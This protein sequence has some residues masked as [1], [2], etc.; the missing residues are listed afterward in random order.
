MA[1]STQGFSG[2]RHAFLKASA[3][4]K[5]QEILKAPI[6]APTG[7]VFESLAWSDRAVSEWIGREVIEVF[8]AHPLW[9]QSH[10]ILLGSW[11]RGELSIK[12]DL[13]LLFCGEANDVFQLITDLQN[14]GYRIRYR[15]PENQK[16]WAEGVESPDCLALWHAKAETPFAA[17]QLKAQQTLIFSNPQI[18]KRI[19]KD[20]L[21]ERKS[22]AERF[23]SIQSFLEPQMKFGPG[24]LRDLFQGQVILDLFQ[25]RFEE[26]GH[27]RQILSYYL[28]FFLTLRLKLQLNG[29][30][31]VLVAPEQFELSKWFGY[32][33]NSEFM[34]QIQRGLSRVHFYSEWI[35]A[36]AAASPTRLQS[37]KKKKFK[38]AMDLFAALKKDPG[39]LTQYEVRLSMDQIAF[40]SKARGEVLQKLLDVK[41][42]DATLQAVFQSRLID[43]LVPQMKKLTGYVQH[44]QYHRFTADAHLLQA[45][46]EV[47]RLQ[48]ASKKSLGPLSLWQKK[49]KPLDWK[50]LA[51]SALYHDLA[52]GQKGDHSEIGEKWVHEDLKAFGLS[53]SF[54]DE[55]AWLVRHHLELSVAAFRKN[56]QAPQTW[57]DLAETGINDPRLLRLLMWTAIDIRATNPEAWNNWKAKLLS[58]LTGKI[59]AG[60]T[61]NFLS[62]RKKLPRG[63]AGSVI[64]ALDPQLFEIFSAKALKAD[65][66]KARASENFSW[67]L[68]KD[69]R[70]K[71]W[72]RFSQKEDRPGVLSQV[73][74]KIYA[75]GGSI[76]TALIHSFPE[77]TGLGIYDWF[78]V[79]TGKEPASFLKLLQQLKSS[80]PIPKVQFL[81]IDLVSQTDSEWIISFRGVDQKGLLLAAAWNLKDLGAQVRSARVHTWGRQIEDLFHVEP[82][83]TQGA[84]PG[85]ESQVFI[86]KLRARLL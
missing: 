1:R 13:D 42:G 57:Q 23:D 68:Q 35:L 61:Q 3:L 31:D 77:S 82:L 7:D 26:N 25:D 22:R 45:C 29:F 53:K 67:S 15:I 40:P 8:R 79:Q 50:I 12:S 37:L 27:E 20:I 2:N 34:R 17:E 36:K 5:V 4:E 54:R 73:L 81:S 84:A 58:D 85:S 39:I 78:Q 70:K 38:K 18:K 14:Q 52:K 43:K 60:G 30:G 48:K 59:L 62:L 46:R 55:V 83:K 63:V 69:S 49:L 10:P 64:E 16:D 24:G 41:T 66:E 76:Q 19:L 75:A 47:F 72:I 28:H 11:G 74:E 9:M 65:L 33:E 6:Q 80:A 44:D 21:A 71:L 32:N 86:E 56:P 51:W